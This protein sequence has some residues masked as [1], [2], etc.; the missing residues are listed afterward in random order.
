MSSRRKVPLTF[1]FHRHGAHPPLFVAGSFSDPPWQPLEMD[2]SIDQHGDL[3][4]TKQ[5]MVNESSEIQYKFRHASGDWWAL[6]PDAETVTDEH[7][8]V[9]SLLLSPSKYATQETT[10]SKEMHDSKIRVEAADHTF[11]IPNDAEPAPENLIT[12]TDSTD[13]DS[14]ERAT[15]EDELRRPSSAPIE[16]IANTAA[17][18]TDSASPLGDDDLEVDG[19]DDFPMFSHECFASSSDSPAPDQQ[20]PEPQHDKL[21]HFSERQDQ[22][23]TDYDDPRL[24]HFPS[25]RG[26]IVAAMRRLSTSIDAD[27]TMADTVPLSPII[28]ARSCSSSSPSPRNSL[29]LDETNSTHNQVGDIGLH[30]T[31]ILAR[32]HSLQSIAEGEETPDEIVSDSFEEFD[33]PTEYIGPLEKPNLSLISSDNSNEDEGIGMGTVS[34]KCKTTTTSLEEPDNEVQLAVTLD[35][36]KS[37][38]TP[39]N[40]ENTSVLSSSTMANETNDEQSSLRKSANGERAHSPSSAYPIFDNTKEYWLLPFFRTIFVD[41][42]GGFVYW[43]CSRSRNQV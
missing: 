27:L 20:E 14:S 37:D 36:T 32:K 2:A 43:L 38:I 3:I 26:S 30:P 40:E 12:A 11:D 42:I 13:I 8:N 33:Q 41:W 9:N 17:E 4:F 5:V 39:P 28:T 16:Q 19:S 34:P 29:H 31:S 15:K 10:L 23:S 25:D 21:D 22:L 6:D 24:E 1:T 18:V 7:G 35:K